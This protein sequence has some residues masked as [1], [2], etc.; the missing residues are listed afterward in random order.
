MAPGRTDGL[1]KIFFPDIITSDGT[2][3]TDGTDG[4]AGTRAT[5]GS[6]LGGTETGEVKS[7]DGISL[8]GRKKRAT[9]ASQ[10]K[11]WY[12]PLGCW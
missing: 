3:G 6:A 7:S 12:A 10:N 8:S 11:G 5:G 4:T 1:E 9:T 2:G